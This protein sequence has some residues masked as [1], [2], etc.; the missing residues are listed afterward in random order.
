MQNEVQ[1]LG[2]EIPYWDKEKAIAIDFKTS[3][4][5][6]DLSHQAELICLLADIYILWFHQDQ[7][8]S[9]LAKDS[10]LCNAALAREEKAAF[11]ESTMQT[12]E[13]TML[14]HFL[15]DTK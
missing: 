3:V 2:M 13:K 14:E 11:V 15:K 1:A 7:Q 4:E 5:R 8:L 9:N 12:N 6:K 10:A